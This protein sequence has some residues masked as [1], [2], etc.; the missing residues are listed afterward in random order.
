LIHQRVSVRNPEAALAIADAF[1]PRGS[2]DKV[3]IESF[4]GTLTFFELTIN[5]PE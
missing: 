4:P 1:V 3:V 2:K 5:F